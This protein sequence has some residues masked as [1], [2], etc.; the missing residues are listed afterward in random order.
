MNLH[1]LH[2]E[3]VAGRAITMFENALPNENIYLFINHNWESYD[4]AKATAHRYDDKIVYLDSDGI[5][6]KDM[7]F[8]SIDR[9]FIHYLDLPKIRFIKKYGL[10]SRKICWIC[11]GGDLTNNILQYLGYKMYSR[12]PGPITERIKYK[13]GIHRFYRKSDELKE[14]LDFIEN[15]LN[16]MATAFSSEF[17]LAK[18]WLPKEMANVSLME[19]FYYPID[20]VLPLNIRDRWSKNKHVFLGHSAS[21]TG[22]HKEAFK[23]LGRIDIKSRKII[24]P[25]NYN[26]TTWN[27]NHIKSLGKKYCGNQCSFLESFMPLSEYNELMLQADRFIFNNWRQE[28]WGNIQ[29][30]LYMG[31]KVFLSKNSLL[32]KHLKELGLHFEYTENLNQT[33]FDEDLTIQQKEENRRIIISMY[34]MQ[35]S[36]RVCKAL[37]EM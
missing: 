19:F 1:I 17:Q 5:P 31:A 21:F 26:G 22:N 7:D 10:E 27:K 3:K 35:R 32:S 13:M 18:K 6:E 20:D 2:P 25:I 34:S 16:V 33:T 4:D 37:C 14:I 8:S 28:A 23:R 12:F 11:W 15:H 24:V 29:I 30:A 36:S 9:V